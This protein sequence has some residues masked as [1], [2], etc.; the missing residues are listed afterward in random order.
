MA[1]KKGLVLGCTALMS[2]LSI[3]SCS[4]TS[5]SSSSTS[6]GKGGSSSSS[7]IAAEKANGAFSYVASSYSERTKIL[8]ALEKYAMQNHIGGL[9]LYGDGGYQVVSS[10]IKYPFSA[11]YITGYGFG[12]MR[13]GSI[14]A[15]DSHFQI[16]DAD[17]SIPNVKEFYHSYDS[18]PI[19]SMNGLDTDG[20]QIA[21]YWSYFQSSFFGTRIKND[22]T[23]AT[24][25]ETEWYPILA[26]TMPVAV[27][28]DAATGLA[29]KW[30]F[31]VRTGD[32]GV[33]YTTDS[34]YRTKWNGQKV[35]AEDYI[36][37]LKVLLTKKIGYYRQSSFTSGSS[38]IKGAAAYY[39]ASADGYNSTAAKAAWEG[40]G[41]KLVDKDGNKWTSGDAYIEIE[42]V[43]PCNE[44]NS[45]YRLSDSLLSPINQEFYEEVCGAPDSDSFTPS[46]YANQSSDKS[47]TAADNVLS[48]GPYTFTRLNGTNNGDIVLTRNAEWFETKANPNLY[49]IK[50]YKYRFDT[51]TSTD[52]NAMI[53]HFKN[54]ECDASSIPSSAWNDY[55]SSDSGDGWVKRVSGNSST[56]KMNINACTQE[57]WEELFGENGSITT[58]S[59]DDYW[60]IKPIM[61]NSDF[62]DGVYF[63]TDRSGIADSMHRN[64]A[65]TYFSE[66]YMSDP[67]NNI[68]YNSTEE[69]KEAIAD[70]ITTDASGNDTYGFDLA[71]AQT[72]FTRAAKELTD[73]GTYKSGDVI[74]L[75][76]YYQ[77]QSQITQWGDMWAK[78]IE[79]A[80]NAAASSYGLTLDIVNEAT[81]VWYDCYYSKAMVGQFDFVFGSISGNT[82]DPLNFMEVLKSDNSSGFTLNWGVDTSKVDDSLVYDGKAWSYDALFNVANS[83]GLVKDGEMA[84]P[85]VYND[86][87]T[88]VDTDEGT[89]TFVYDYDNDLGKQA[90]MNFDDVTVACNFSYIDADGDAHSYLDTMAGDLYLQAENDSE[91]HTISFTLTVDDLLSY[92][93]GSEAAAY[94]DKPIAEGSKVTWEDYF[95][96]FITGSVSTKATLSMKFT[97]SVTINGTTGSY[98]VSTLDSVSSFTTTK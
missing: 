35:S 16:A 1:I 34:S 61:S 45:Y 49:K 5:G 81:T 55:A 86:K 57:R 24:N 20:S 8:G 15:T 9:T 46:N 87:K 76:T 82:L 52:A 50:G 21:D 27:N 59:K 89:I 40:V 11:G 77:G 38:Q 18:T 22:D 66:A 71:Q 13:Y 4:P 42:Y 80:F 37:A 69:H 29:S 23:S 94:A 79:D 84:V 17:T 70:Y 78:T 30:R 6:G 12:T 92:Y 64:K 65:Y 54:K 62:L 44:F 68:S 67:E 60:E 97:Q 96:A 74:K 14:D 10:R 83:G 26:K 90:N 48:V 56:Y 3:V 36:F 39:A 41:F 72:L 98:T 25:L 19:T 73:N 32:D 2:L 93:F 33:T 53:T 51:N 47:K 85:Y 43:T 63:A 58:T 91:K 95:K 75:Y 28:K 7:T 31:Q 88:V